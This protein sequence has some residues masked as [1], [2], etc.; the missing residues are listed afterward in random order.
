[1]TANPPAPPEL[2]W[3]TDDNPVSVL[4]D[5]PYFAREDGRAETHEVFVTG[6]GLPERWSERSRFTIAELGFGTGLS[7]FETLQTWR[8]NCGPEQHLDY[9]SFERYPISWDDLQRALSVW[10]DLAELARPLEVAWPP[11]DGWQTIDFETVALHL[12]IGDA[13]D[14]LPRWH[15]TADA[16]YLDGFS[17]AKNPD[18]WSKEL[19]QAVYD[20]TAPGGTFS[21]YTAAGWVRRNLSGAGFIV[22]KVSGFGRKRE[23]LAGH[24]P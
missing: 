16:W 22:A 18:L 23:R 2:N 20:R 9:V 8:M 10:P 14:Q 1:M 7:F 3:D 4:F 19:M 12:V 13:N 17:P 11:A 15:D 5:D 24:H 6:N 21:T